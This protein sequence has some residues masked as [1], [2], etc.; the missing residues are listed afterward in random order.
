MF[1]RLRVTRGS[2]AKV[3]LAEL[4]IS[5]GKWSFAIAIAVS[6]LRHGGPGAVG[7][8]AAARL[9]PATLAAPLVTR[10]LDQA[11]RSRMV[12][13]TCANQGLFYGC[14]SLTVIEHGPLVL[15]AVL[16]ALGS[17]PASAARPALQA[18]I[19]AL[20]RHPDEVTRASALWAAADNAGTVIGCGLGAALIAAVGS[21][22]IAAG[23]A[24]AIGAAAAVAAALPRTRATA[25]DD[26]LEEESL[27]AALAGARAVFRSPLL[28]A[29][30]LLFLGLLL[31][32]GTTDVQLVALAIR[33]LRLGSGGPGLFLALWGIGG[34]LAGL[35]LLALVRRRG[36]GLV[37]GLG[38]IV[39][40]A[41]IGVTGV[42][43]R[44][45]ALVVMVPAGIGFSLV[46]TGVMAV[47]PRLADDAIVGRV[48]GL[49]EMIYTGGAGVGALLAPG[50]IGAVG[51]GMSLVVVGSTLL[52]LTLSLLRILARLDV[53]QE[54][55]A[56]VRDLLRGIPCLGALP[57]PRLERLV[58]EAQPLHVSTGET[59]IRKGEP[60][61]AFYVLEHGEVE[62]V[63]FD[64]RQGPGSGFGEIALL[65]DIPRTA[66][67]RALAD[68]DLL[69]ISRRLFVAAVTSHGDATSHAEAMVEENMSRSLA[70]F[71]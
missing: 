36:Y 63:G 12:V 62:I 29:P 15:I 11:D 47:V 3:L 38:A 44:V 67:V 35:V 60:G 70:A 52:L 41:A 53:H 71:E 5:A 68:T 26:E 21:G 25:H 23:G 22:A 42:S 1:G 58:Q 24:A 10:L 19:P 31:L 40:A 66:T 50:L 17:A 65:R 46:E 57:L 20:A 16:T 34:T 39:F 59:I 48:Y 56:S 18:L 55:A 69:R 14:V 27:A 54:R 30:F 8:V 64:R 2:L 4:L 7:L 33:N 45:V 49:M 32:E 13:L 6:A 9:L 28:R 61:D 51:V 37:I 43:G